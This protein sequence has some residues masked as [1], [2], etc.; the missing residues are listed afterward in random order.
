VSFAKGK[1]CINLAPTLVSAQIPKRH[2]LACF[3]SRDE[4]EIVPDY[5]RLRGVEAQLLKT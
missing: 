3:V 1:R 5:G 2:V 4:R